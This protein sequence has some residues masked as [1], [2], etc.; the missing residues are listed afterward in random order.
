MGGANL[1]IFK[2]G[3]YLFTPIYVMVKFA[4]PDWY[5]AYVAPLKEQ[6][7]PPYEETH[8]PPKTHDAV[9]SELDRMKAE[10]LAGAKRRQV[11]QAALG[12]DG[13]VPE[14]QAGVEGGRGQGT[15]T[16]WKVSGGGRLV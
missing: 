3:F 11:D 10:R 15:G 13:V 1:E 6:F 8:Q 2:F 16:R 14:G 12:E 5:A 9:R 7:W 4:D